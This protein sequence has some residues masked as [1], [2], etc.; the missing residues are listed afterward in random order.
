MAKSNTTVIPV[1]RPSRKQTVYIVVVVYMNANT[2]PV[3][4]DLC[5][6]AVWTFC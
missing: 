5:C 2:F 6:G 3:H 4:G 1:D